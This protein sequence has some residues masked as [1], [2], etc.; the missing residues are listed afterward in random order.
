MADV[1]ISDLSDVSATGDLAVA[2]I[3]P[4]VDASLVGV[5]DDNATTSVTLD[6]LKDFI[7]NHIVRSGWD[8]V[9]D[10]ALETTSIDVEEDTWTV[11]TNDGTSSATKREF[12]PY[13]AS[14]IW[15]V[16]DNKIYMDQLQTKDVIWFRITLGGKP[17]TNNTLVKMRINYYNK[18]E[19]GNVNF[20]FQKNFVDQYME[21]GAGVE[22][23]KEF[24][25]PFYIGS[26]STIRGYGE[27]EINCNTE[28]EITDV[29]MLSVVN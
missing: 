11:L 28:T 10:K 24:T 13:G 27:L 3:I 6:I 15:N 7:S 12:L 14:R 18:D 4:I 9:S 8:Y 20:N 17:S 23:V 16:S 19:E 26:E 2:D 25:V 21:D 22:H 29:A 5:D 1:K